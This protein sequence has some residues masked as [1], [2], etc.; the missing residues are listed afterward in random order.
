MVSEICKKI[1][2][3]VFW[4][5]A[6]IAAFIAGIYA[7]ISDY[8]GIVSAIERLNYEQKELIYD[9]LLGR[10]LGSIIPGA[11]FVQTYALLLAGVKML[12]LLICSHIIMGIFTNMRDYIRQWEN[13]ENRRFFATALMEQVMLFGI[14][15]IPSGIILWMDY[16]LYKYRAMCDFLN[17]GVTDLSEVVMEVPAWNLFVEE[18]QHLQAANIINLTAL[19]Y[20]MIAILCCLCFE[21]FKLQ[22]TE[23]FSWALNLVEDRVVGL[24]NGDAPGAYYENYRQEDADDYAQYDEPNVSND[25]DSTAEMQSESNHGETEDRVNT[26]SNAQ[27][28]DNNIEATLY[29]VI[30]AA[31]PSHVT[32]EEAIQ[33]REHYVYDMQTDEVYDAAYYESLHA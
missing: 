31:Q 11:T 13:R 4:S 28:S 32:R 21:F 27:D 14:M 33:D 29:E 2:A 5:I 6:T 19:G 12:M 15:S 18:Y 17:V 26:S 30:G 20:S 1:F 9:Q 25:Y 7:G 16:S 23:S 8:M 24:I 10:Y 22:A 3:M